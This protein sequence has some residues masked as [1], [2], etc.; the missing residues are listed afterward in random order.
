MQKLLEIPTGEVLSS[1]LF[2]GLAGKEPILWTNGENVVFDQGKVRKAQGYVGLETLSARMTGCKAAR[3]I[4]APHLYFGGGGAY[5]RYRAS[6][7]ITALKSGLSGAGIWIFA[8]YGEH[9]VATDGVNG[10]RYYD[11]ADTLIAT[12]F[13]NC[14]TMFGFRQQVFAAATSNGYNWIEWCDIDDAK[15][16]WTP[17]LGNAAGNLQPR[18]LDGGFVAAHK[19]AGELIG[20]YTEGSLGHFTY[21]GGTL[22]YGYKTKVPGAG[23]VSHY[24]VVPVRNVHYSIMRGRAIVTDGIVFD[25]ID[26][27]AVRNYLDTVVN[28]GRSAEVFGWHDKLNSTIRWVLPTGVA[29]FVGLGYRYDSR[30]WTK[31]NDNLLIGEESGVWENAM[32]FKTTRL[33]RGDSTE[34]NNDGAAF[35]SYV[36]TKPLD[37]GDR[38]RNKWVDKIV[39]DLEKTGTVELQVGFSDDANDA[40]TWNTAQVAVDGDNFMD[41]DERRE[42]LFV[43]LK[44]SSS[45]TDNTW[46]LGS[47]SI[48][49]EPA[50]W[51]N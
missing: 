2:P 23:A 34:M 45:G 44:I 17:T 22:Q 3:V 26:D 31:F 50:G 32:V 1:G 24:A 36:Q 21:L 4:A 46:K 42:G 47:F 49:G 15:T 48:H 29:D 33:L 10:L 19:L 25:Y 38:E 13:T 51:K 40:P 6:D 14:R 39:L 5:Y 43:H 8:P 41:E 18:D 12:P 11:G 28:W 16:G 20:L 27:P 9:L 35:T 30:R 7:G 37:C